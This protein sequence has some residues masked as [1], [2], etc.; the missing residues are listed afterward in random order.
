MT[1]KK[2]EQKKEEKKIGVGFP[3]TFGEFVK[4]PV[5]GVMFLILIA[6]SYLYVDGK[7]NYNK[8]IDNQGKKIELLENKVDI[9]V[10]QVRVADSLS[11]SL[12]SKIS[13]LQELGKIK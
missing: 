11:A 9:L 5:K 6:I 8:Q 12:S 13:V 10:N 2:I 3:I 4:E 7:M 1:R